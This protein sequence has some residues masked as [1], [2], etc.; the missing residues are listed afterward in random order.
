MSHFNAFPPVVHHSS[1]QVST[2]QAQKL[3][4]D[5][6]QRTTTDTSLHPNAHFTPHGPVNPSGDGSTGIV[7]H[8]LK[9]IEAGL[10]GEH[11]SADVLFQNLGEG[12]SDHI[13]TNGGRAEEQGQQPEQE[14]IDDWQDKEEYEREQGVEQG[15]VGP[16]NHAVEHEN[17]TSLVNGSGEVP[18]V[19][20]AIT[21]QDREERKRKKKE[22]RKQEQKNRESG[23]SEGRVQIDTA[24]GTQG[25]KNADKV[26]TFKAGKE[27]GTVAGE[28]EDATPAKKKDR[29]DRKHKD[30]KTGKHKE[31]NA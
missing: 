29:R 28:P 25:L 7:L 19:N 24:A 18:T 26:E 14:F 3:L 5:F 11:L 13:A 8:N 4:A 17:Q 6:L 23:I 16:R 1:Q 30:S 9:R 12:V 2:G 27:R 21:A 20:R 10:R 31:Q 15:E 22:R